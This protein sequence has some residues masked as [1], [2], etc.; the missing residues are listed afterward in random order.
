[1]ALSD[2]DI[3]FAEV[4]SRGSNFHPFPN[5]L[6][7]LLFLLLH[8]PKPMVNRKYFLT[9]MAL[10]LYSQNFSSR[11]ENPTSNLYGSL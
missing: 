8:T 1:M 4:Q 3:L 5:K 9:I 11:R 6:F 10:L 7:A 2:V